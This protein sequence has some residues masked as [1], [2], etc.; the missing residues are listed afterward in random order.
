MA[1]VQQFLIQL[2]VLAADRLESAH[3]T[4]ALSS[5]MA[6]LRSQLGG[7]NR[8]FQALNKRRDITPECTFEYSFNRIGLDAQG[9]FADRNFDLKLDE[10]EIGGTKGD[11]LPRMQYEIKYRDGSCH[12]SGRMRTNA[13]GKGYLN[14]LLHEVG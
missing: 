11:E 12:V 1:T 8:L 5:T 9:F 13:L 7:A 4:D 14:L 6:E 10:V 2:A 3:V